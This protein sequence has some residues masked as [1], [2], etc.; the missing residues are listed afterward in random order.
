MARKLIVLTERLLVVAGCTVNQ[1]L[2]APSCHVSDS[3]LDPLLGLAQRE[4]LALHLLPCPETWWAGL[5]REPRG[6][7]WY[8][9]QNGFRLLCRDLA[10]QEAEKLKAMVDHRS[11]AVIGVVGIERSPACS[12]RQPGT[13]PGPSSYYPS[14]LFMEELRCTLRDVGLGG[15]PFVSITGSTT[16]A[17]QDKLESL[18]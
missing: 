15:V 1:L 11:V 12:T 10:L 4:R 14:G 3:V 9:R 7:T 8:A 18:L 16:Q 5:D 6:R 17:Q 13:T 2:R